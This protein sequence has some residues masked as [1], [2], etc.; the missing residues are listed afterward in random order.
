[1]SQ[2]EM[3]ANLQS[4]KQDNPGLEK[5][6]N[7]LFPHLTDQSMTTDQM[8]ALARLNAEVW[9]NDGMERVAGWY[10]RH[11]SIW[12]FFIALIL[13]FALNVDSLQIANKLWAEPTLRQVVAAQASSTPSATS[14]SASSPLQVPT[15]LNS[16]SIPVG[17]TTEP[18]TDYKSCGFVIGQNTPPGY[19][20]QNDLG[21]NQCNE[22]ANLPNMNSLIGWLSKLIGLLITALAG[23]QGSPFWFDVLKKLVNVRGSGVTPTVTPAPAPTAP[24]PAPASMPA[25]STNGPVG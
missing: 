5:I 12:S 11:N 25:P 15:Y 23:A 14:T 1:M 6:I 16:L 4:V 22:F 20:G 2:N 17:W 10:K 9:F 3:T 21:Q 18:V 13:A 19:V 7:H 24:T 8:L